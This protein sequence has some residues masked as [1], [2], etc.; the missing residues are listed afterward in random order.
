MDQYPLVRQFLETNPFDKHHAAQ[1][2]DLSYHIVPA[3][4]YFLSLKDV[5]GYD[6]KIKDIR[7]KPIGSCKTNNRTIEWASLCAEIG[8]VCILGKTLGLT[9]F[10]LEEPSP[11]AV[12]A[13]RTCDIGAKVNDGPTLYFEVKRKSSEEKQELPDYLRRKLKE[14]QTRI[15]L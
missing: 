12:R 3:L 9:I 14:V 6:K 5:R 4:E 2:L 11:R 10:G 13:G 8:A 1:G 15:G 7:T